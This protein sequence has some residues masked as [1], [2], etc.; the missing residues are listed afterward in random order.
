[1]RCCLCGIERGG[2][3]G[4]KDVPAVREF[5]V[6]DQRPEGLTM[7]RRDK[8]RMIVHQ[9]HPRG[10]KTEHHVG[11]SQTVAAPDLGNGGATER[12][13]IRQ[14]LQQ[15]SADAP[16]A[17]GCMMKARG[18]DVEV[19]MILDPQEAFDAPT[20]SVIERREHET[21]MSQGEAEGF[22]GHRIMILP[23]H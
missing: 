22:H 12:G 17:F 6:F 2:I 9:V 11:S 18:D 3:S 20:H 5:R 14:V 19:G 10:T 8:D 15:G 23:A 13:G 16:V 7:K 4:G 1:M 21:R